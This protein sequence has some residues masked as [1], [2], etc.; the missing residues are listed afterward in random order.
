[1]LIGLMLAG[2]MSRSAATA[3]LLVPTSATAMIKS[4]A[5]ARI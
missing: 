3:T 4:I 2:A 1:M 5:D